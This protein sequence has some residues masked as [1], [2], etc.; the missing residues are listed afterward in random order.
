MASE[1]DRKWDQCLARMIVNGGM[2]L[3]V[4]VGLSAIVFRRRLWPISMSFGFACG[5]SYAE[6]RHAFA[7]ENNL[8]PG[9]KLRVIQPVQAKAEAVKSVTKAAGETA[10]MEKVQGDAGKTEKP[11]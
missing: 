7:P 4:G 2:G 10:A 6:C 9:A 1:L 11:Q 3:A 8:P 5:L